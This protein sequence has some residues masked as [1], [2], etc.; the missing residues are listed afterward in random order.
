M[1]HKHDWH[2]IKEWDSKPKQSPLPRGQWVS[3]GGF[4]GGVTYIPGFDMQTVRERIID[5]IQ[6]SEMPYYTFQKWQCPGCG[7]IKEYSQKHEGI[8]ALLSKKAQ[9]A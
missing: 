3:R 9:K 6:N 4:F 7:K 8:S 5:T 1:A 2:L